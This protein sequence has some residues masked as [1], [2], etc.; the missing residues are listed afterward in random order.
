MVLGDPVIELFGLQR[1]CSPWVENHN[2]K[3]SDPTAWE[4]QPCPSVA[5][6]V[7]APSFWDKGVKKLSM[8]WVHKT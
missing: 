7:P 8:L 6:S 5:L 2:S 3:W 1:G 4:S